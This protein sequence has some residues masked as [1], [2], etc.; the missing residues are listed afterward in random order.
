[1][2]GNCQ[3]ICGTLLNLYP[4]DESILQQPRKATLGGIIFIRGAPHGLTVSHPLRKDFDQSHRSG[5]SVPDEEIV[6]ISFLEG[7]D[8]EEIV[9]VSSLEDSDDGEFVQSSAGLSESS[10]AGQYLH[11]RDCKLARCYAYVTDCK[12]LR[13]CLSINSRITVR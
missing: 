11:L 3:S 8:D 10:Q 6:E 4:P 12:R 13:R 2:S 5:E 7:S 9:E 1:M